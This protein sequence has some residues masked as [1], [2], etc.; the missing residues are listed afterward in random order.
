MKESS[1]LS[2]PEGI[3][4]VDIG[5]TGTSGVVSVQWRLSPE[6][7]DDFIPP[8]AGNVTF[9]AVS[10]LIYTCISDNYL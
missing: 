5:R 1:S 8:L 7:A 10:I 2:D 6:A 3:V 4:H 9:T